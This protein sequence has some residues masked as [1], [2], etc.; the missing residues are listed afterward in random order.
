MNINLESYLFSGILTKTK[1]KR[2]I[3]IT[4][5]MLTSLFRIIGDGIV[6]SLLLFDSPVFFIWQLITFLFLSSN[7]AI[8]FFYEYIDN[9]NNTA[10][11]S[12]EHF[13][14]ELNRILVFS[15]LLF[16]SNLLLPFFNNQKVIESNIF[17][18][19]LIDFI[20]IFGIYLSFYILFFLYKWLNIYKH[21]HT[22]IYIKIILSGL[23]LLF[24]FRIVTFHISGLQNI[25]SN[26][27][28]LTS[29]I[30]GFLAFLLNKKN[31]WLAFIPREQK[32]KILWFSMFNIVISLINSSIL[33]DQ[34]NEITQTMLQILPGLDLILG[35]SFIFVIAYFS[36]IVLTLIISMPTSSILERKTSEI[37][38]FADLN[39]YVSKTIDFNELINTVTRLAI[40]A[41]QGVAGWTELYTKNEKIEIVSNYLVKENSINEL[42]SNKKFY[43]Y[44]KKINEPYLI[45]S[46]YENRELVMLA[47]EQLQYAKSLII[48]PLISNNN[49]IGTLV[50]LHSEEYGFDNGTLKVLAAFSDNVSIAIDNLNLMKESIEKERYKRELLLAREIQQNLLPRKIPKISNCSVEAFSIP[51][52]EVGGDYYDV[53]KLRNNLYCIVIGDVSGKGVSAAFYMAQLKGVVIALSNEAIGAADLLKKINSTLFGLMEKQMFIT[54]SALV[55]DTEKQKIYFS[56]AGHMPLVMKSNNEIKL[57][58]PK[59]IG[60]GLA[61]SS[62]FNELLEEISI[63]IYPGDACILFTDGISELKDSSQQELGYESMKLILQNTVYN[64]NALIINQKIKKLIDDSVEN[65]AYHDDMTIVSIVFG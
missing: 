47:W 63:D 28:I 10:K 52:E 20:G 25:H 64:N 56:R 57:F 17:L 65:S 21:K 22:K 62:K 7:I 24:L 14:V 44:V 31:T 60:I 39:K 33:L 48:I 11:N 1:Y 13:I 43:N 16:I 45:E 58:T 37:S 59:G 29:I 26:V 3:L 8:Y 30:L 9:K 5:F 55:I 19:I 53:I 2:S 40:N 6:Y 42:H 54:L 27:T 46:I 4:V 12:T 41:S 50:L 36:R 35:F 51:A 23:L 32:N 15:I 34:K 38:S 49:R 18:V 61:Q